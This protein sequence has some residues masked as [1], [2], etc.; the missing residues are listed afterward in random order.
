MLGFKLR[1]NGRRAPPVHPEMLSQRRDV[2]A[3]PPR[4]G[5]LEGCG[6]RLAPRSVFGMA[7]DV[8]RNLQSSS[9]LDPAGQQGGD[10]CIKIN[11][12]RKAAAWRLLPEGK[13][14]APVRR[15]PSITPKRKIRTFRPAKS[16]PV[17][18]RV[19]GA[20]QWKLDESA[21]SF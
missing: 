2:S 18:F 15:E 14:P 21:R 3:P 10:F 7:A 11:K 5:S 12:L 8:R 13:S 20:V 1:E 9:E 16:V 17:H 19:R 4:R 6:Y